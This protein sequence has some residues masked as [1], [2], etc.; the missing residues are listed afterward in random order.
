MLLRRAAVIDLLQHQPIVVFLERIQNNRYQN[1]HFLIA[2]AE[3]T[4]H[5]FFQ[6]DLRESAPMLRH[7][8]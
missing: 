2:L 1:F 4:L 5:H 6:S 3:K 7:F 8:G